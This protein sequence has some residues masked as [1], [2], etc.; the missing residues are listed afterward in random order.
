MIVCGEKHKNNF[1]FFTVPQI[2]FRIIL[3]EQKKIS[4][5]FWREK[6]I[7]IDYIFFSNTLIYLSPFFFMFLHDS[8]VILI[9]FFS[10][11]DVDGVLLLSSAFKETLWIAKV[12]EYHKKK[13]WVFTL[14]KIKWKNVKRIQNENNLGYSLE[15]NNFVLIFK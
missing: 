12:I 4:D 13:N 14:S 5:L 6:N 8:F 11:Q 9:V 3:F 15:I 7:K 2:T 1:T 10:R